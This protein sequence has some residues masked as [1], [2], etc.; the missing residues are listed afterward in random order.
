MTIIARWLKARVES[1]SAVAAVDIE[2]LDQVRVVVVPFGIAAAMTD[3][4][5]VV[6]HKLDIQVLSLRVVGY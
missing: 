1:D 3:V 4:T 2:E 6:V 5:V